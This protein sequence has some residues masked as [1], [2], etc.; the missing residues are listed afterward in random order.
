MKPAPRRKRS[1]RLEV[2][3]TP[4]ER[5]LI[6]RAVS[7]TGEDMTEFVVAHAC[8]AASRVLADRERF[9]L[10]PK[11][12][13]AWEAINAREARVLPGLRKLMGRKSPF[14]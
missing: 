1:Q 9:S 6:Q 14:R 12:L 7:L 11:A 3:T 10:S 13:R 4:E 2:R 5:E 8:E